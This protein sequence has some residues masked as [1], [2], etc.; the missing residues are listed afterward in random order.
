MRLTESAYSSKSSRNNGSRR[1]PFL[2]LSRS[3]PQTAGDHFTLETISDLREIEKL[4]EIWKPWQKT[5]DS[6]LDFFCEMVRSRGIGCR[7]HVIV[8]SRNARPDALLV[9][10]RDRTKMPFRLCSVTVHQP[11][12]K[13]LEFVY[14]GLLGNASKENCAALVRAVMQSLAQGDADIALWE[15]LDVHS[16]LYTCALQL[17]CLALRDH[18]CSLQDHWFMNCPKGLD[19]FLAS[20]GRSRR[21]K[22]R[23]K[24]KRVLNRFPVSLRVRSFRT[25]ADLEQ[26]MPDMEQIA[27]KS[28]KRQFGFG[29]ANTPSAREKLIV[30]A[31]RGWLRIYILYFEQNPVAFW[32]GT[33]HERCLQAD[34]S[35]YDSAWSMFSPGI[36]LFL[37]ILENLRD[38]DVKTVDLG[39]GKGQLYNCFGNMRYL[40]ARVQICAPRFRGFQLNLLHTLAHYVTILIRRIRWLNW[41]RRAV[42]KRFQA[43]ALFTGARGPETL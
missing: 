10:L 21:S 27:R 38:D 20:L 30:E 4:R 35:G 18:S 23:R 42:W 12:V 3:E 41:A 6:D 34:H 7:P 36:F 37:D 31:T 13:V 33:L 11:E 2:K 1:L 8:L 22:L 25:I 39:C 43:K 5:R 9:G 28:V 32:K 26:A 15:Q 14:G 24:Y 19:A 17:P 16:A 40:E 29:F